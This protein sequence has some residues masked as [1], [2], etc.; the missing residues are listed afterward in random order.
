MAD[1]DDDLD[2]IDLTT[3]LALELRA[4]AAI[5]PRLIPTRFSLLKRMEQSPAHYHYACQLPQND[6]LASRL[7]ALTTDRSGALRFGTAVHTFL[8]GDMTRVEKYPA[9]RAGKAWEAFRVEC[10]ERGVVEIL[11]EREYTNA[12]EV[13]AAIRRNERAMRL[14]F[15]GTIVEQRIDWNFVGKLCRSTPDAR[16]PHHC[17]DL[18][19]AR[20]AHPVEFVRQALRL[21]YH[22]QQA[23]YADAIEANGEPRP[24]E[25][26][27]IAV[28]KSPPHPVSIL[29]LTDRALEAGAKLCRLW[30][31][32]VLT[33][34][35]TG[36][37]PEYLD[38]IGSF[39]I[40]DLELEF[41]G[42]RFT[43]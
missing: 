2:L 33:C 38:D 37:W 4:N 41:D 31:E 7:G 21:H 27:L 15:D 8:L 36:R 11:N 40:D 25:S 23:L 26:F 24:A 20:S 22:A 9:R 16:S 42:R 43:L 28:E 13:A 32:Q 3:E 35:A 39:D 34:E 19:T 14:M 29:R 6:S 10:A 30:V 17:T 18:K 12:T 5:D 1:D